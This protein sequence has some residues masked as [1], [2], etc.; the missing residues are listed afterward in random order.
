MPA[1]KLP[2]PSL[3]TMVLGV[4]FEVAEATSEAMVVIVPD[5]VAPDAVVEAVVEA[6]VV[7]EEVAVDVPAKK[8]RTKKPAA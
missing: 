1:L 7:T 5:A 4:L 2:L 8:K 3:L 6:P